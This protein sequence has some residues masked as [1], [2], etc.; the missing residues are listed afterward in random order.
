MIS[1]VKIIYDLYNK[2]DQY[3]KKEMISTI[4]KKL[5]QNNKKENDHY[6]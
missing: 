6:N 3:N 5:D 4:K 1:T 2:K